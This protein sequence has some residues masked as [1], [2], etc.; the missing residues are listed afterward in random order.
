LA[1][2]DGAQGVLSGVMLKE[3]LLEE[4]GMDSRL[5]VLSTAG[6]HEAANRW[7][8]STALKAS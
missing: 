8:P 3:R 1:A 2:V 6:G 5:I 4:D 7:Q